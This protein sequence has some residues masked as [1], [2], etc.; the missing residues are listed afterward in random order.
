MT[1]D[2][3]RIASAAVLATAC[4]CAYLF[5]AGAPGVYLAVNGVSLLIGLSLAG[6]LSGPLDRAGPLNW[7]LLQLSAGFLIL[8]A[9][10]LGVGL[11]GVSRWLA[12]GPILLQPGLILIP[13]ML[14]RYANQQ[15]R[16]TQ[17]ALL[18]TITAVALQPDRSLSAVLFV[19]SVCVALSTRDRNGWL[20]AIAAALGLLTSL[21]QVDSLAG[22]GFV[23][24]VY[25]DAFQSG[26]LTAGL[27]LAGTMVMLLPGLIAW[28][29]HHTHSLAPRVFGAV[30]LT[31]VCSAWAGNYPTPL[32]GYG[33]SA[34]LG[35]ALCLL[36]I[37]GRT[38]DQTNAR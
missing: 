1:S 2:R 11:D 19:G 17:I 8:F 14:V 29:R 10:L 38:S 16:L 36:A 18:I 34:I 9:S 7:G 21:L 37:P 24:G 28:A 20:V 35:Y 4:G 26:R 32:L 12:L 23:E 33:S 22:V 30:W 27:V 25:R 13:L 5:F 31:L 15:D 6:M 3:F